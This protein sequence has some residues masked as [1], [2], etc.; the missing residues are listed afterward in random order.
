MS[1]SKEEIVMMKLR[2]L[3]NKM[4]QSI[5]AFKTKNHSKSNLLT[6]LK[7]LLLFRKKMLT[8]RRQSKNYKN[9]IKN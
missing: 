2:H 8:K 7:T 5:K 6:C 3:L 1:M 9:K 4:T